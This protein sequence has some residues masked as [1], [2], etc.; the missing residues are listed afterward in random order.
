MWAAETFHFHTLGLE[1]PE[2]L[3]VGELIPVCA[4]AAGKL[5][6]PEFLL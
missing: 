3:M 4:E 5:R 2:S 1:G 6:P